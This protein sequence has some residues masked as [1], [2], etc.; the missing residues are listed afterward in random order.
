VKFLVMLQKA[1]LIAGLLFAAGF[2]VESSVGMP[3]YAAV[4]LDDASKT[5]V[6]LPC[7]EDWRSRRGADFAIA[8]LSKV[9]EAQALHYK[10]DDDC[11]ESGGYIDDDRSLSGLFLVK[12][13]VLPT[14]QHW[15]DR[16]Y[17]TEEG[18]VQ[19]RS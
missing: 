13:G 16:P 6:A 10:L 1:G 11:R 8:R 9:S 4:Y 7:I 5:Y 12:L 18:I 2:G 3:G 15:W 19:P 14:K 17:R